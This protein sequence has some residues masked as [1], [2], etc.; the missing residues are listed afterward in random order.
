MAFSRFKPCGLSFAFPPD[1]RRIVCLATFATLFLLSPA[2]S[3]FARAATEGAEALV[4]EDFSF[5]FATVDSKGDKTLRD[6]DMDTHLNLARCRCQMPLTIRAVLGTAAAAKLGADEVEAELW[7]GT[8]C[9]ENPTPASCLKLSMAAAK[10]S[11]TNTRISATTT[12][13][14]L[15]GHVDA[16]KPDKCDSKSASIA[17]WLILKTEGA[18][19]KI[20]KSKDLTVDSTPPAPPVL[21]DV[22]AGNGAATLNWTHPLRSDLQGYQA[23]CL[24]KVDQKEP[25]AVYDFC[26]A[27]EPVS[28]FTRCSGKIPSA[29][30]NDRL[31]GLTNGV[32][33]QVGIVAIDKQGNASAM[34]AVMPV[35]PAPSLDFFTVYRQ[36]GGQAEGGCQMAARGRPHGATIF[37]VFATLVLLLRRLGRRITVV[38]LLLLAASGLGTSNAHAQLNLQ[39]ESYNSSWVDHGDSERGFNLSLGMGF[40]RPHVDEE[41]KNSGTNKAP[42]KEVFS[43]DEDSLWHL[44]LERI[45][46]RK[47]GTLSLGFGAGYYHVEANAPNRDRT[48]PSADKTGLRVIPLSLDLGYQLDTLVDRGWGVMPFV[49]AGLDDAIWSVSNA[50]STVARGTTTGWHGA[51]GLAFALDALD[52]DAARQLDRDTGVN[53]TLL[54]AELLHQ[55]LTG[56]GSKPSLHLSDTML[57]IGLLLQM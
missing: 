15:F 12:V 26:R 25:E 9:S 36:D 5:E 50:T 30:K 22:V 35:T 27:T 37:A 32:P 40:Y 19:L 1:M 7:W 24:P 3:H 16:T 33:Y 4:A 31:I 21:T 29:S 28:M 2:V 46:W 55:S 13:D 14:T 34:S 18:L 52:P 6:E 54:F 42:F 8:G 48:M 47:V 57:S 20:S 56:L 17:V 51:V 44:R 11:T 38:A 49:R 43:T 41:F 23:F 39:D 10:F 53:H 45:L